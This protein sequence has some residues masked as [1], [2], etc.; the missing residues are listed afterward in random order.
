MRL[1]N[2]LLAAVAI[3]LVGVVVYVIIAPEQ[4][5]ERPDA[6]Y[7]TSFE[8]LDANGNGIVTQDELAAAYP[9]VAE[10]VIVVIDGDAD[11]EISEEEHASAADAGLLPE[12]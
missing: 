2:L 9:E 1:H 7:A 5:A 12:G 8:D 10:E 3:V 4:I 6:E 11:G